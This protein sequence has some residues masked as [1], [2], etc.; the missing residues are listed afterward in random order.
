VGATVCIAFVSMS[1]WAHHMFTI[2]MNSYANSFF[3]ITTMAVGVPTGIKISTGWAR[4][5]RQD[6]VQDADVVLHRFLFQFLIAGLTVMLAR[7]PLTGS[8][9]APTCCGH[10]HYVIVGGILSPY[11]VHFITGTQNHRKNLNEAWASCI[12][13]CF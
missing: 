11:S 4:C 6:S 12:S 2:G 8:S 3:T 13:G 10:F 7:R 5:G 1:V 9:A